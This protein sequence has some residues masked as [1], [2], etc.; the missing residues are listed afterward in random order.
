MRRFITSLVVLLLWS[1]IVVGQEAPITTTKPGNIT[2]AA[3]LEAFFD[4]AMRVP[5]ESKH[6]AGGVV[7]VVVNG[8]VVFTKGYGYADIAERKPVDPEKTMLRIASIS[9]PFTWTAV[10]QQVEEGKLDL[11]ADV[12]KYLKDVQIPATMQQPITLKNFLTHTPGFEDH[13]IGLFAKEPDKRPLREILKTQIPMRVRPPGT[14]ASYSNHGTALAGYAVECVSGQPWEEYL[15]ARIFKPLGM[16]HT[17]ARQPAK[18]LLSADLSKSYKWEGGRFVDKGFEYVPAAPAGCLSASALDMTKFMMAHLNDGQ[19]GEARI[20]KA[21]TAKKMREPLFRHD[22][23]VSAMCYGFFE[24]KHHG[25]RLIGHGGDTIYFH[26]LM[27]LIPEKNVGYFISFNTD[28]SAGVR[29][30]IQEAFLS[31][32][33]PVTLQAR[34][35]PN[36]SLKERA[37]RLAG[38]YGGT[39]YSHSTLAKL[40]S[41]MSVHEVNVND[42]DTI[43]I[44]SSGNA[45]RF[46]EVQPFQFKELDGTREVVFQTDKEGNV[47]HLFFGNGPH[48]SAIK[49]KWYESPNVQVGLLLVCVVL[50]AT[51]LLVWPAVGWN[52][53]GLESTTVR[54]SWFSAFLSW[55]AWLMCLL[56]MV[57]AG[58][59][60][61]ALLDPNE[62]VFGISPMLSTILLAAQVIA[63][64][65]AVTL[66]GCLIAWVMR[67]WRFS[68]RLH[69]TLV[70]LAGAGFVWSLYHWNLLKF[71]VN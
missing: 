54:R 32:Y 7:A 48:S 8:K 61:L 60:V 26:S 31:R 41:L 42:D 53:R 35:K 51:A 17:T 16:K 63:G 6:I 67:Y 3:D 12:N 64:L 27:Q 14:L 11:D 47:V 68:G 58:A 59:L 70:A 2:D 49:L 62:L 37:S 21:E 34:V 28:T 29:E 69:Y 30:Q 38:E 36:G 1:L 33:Y 50:F 66:L 15:E 40:G 13:V 52:V 18:E 20:L 23:R 56:S 44:V 25:L 45:R 10:M 71:G 43:T 19:L 39:R 55:L 65:A 22:D 46:V 5:M 57:F 4:G 9:K 24:E